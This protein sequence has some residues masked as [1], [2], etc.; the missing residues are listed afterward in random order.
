MVA[1]AV[2]ALVITGAGTTEFTVRLNVLLLV[3]SAL[4]WTVAV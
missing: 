3:A 1:A 4:S 2:V